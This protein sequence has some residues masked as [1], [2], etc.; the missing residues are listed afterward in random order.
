MILERGVKK[1]T[2]LI[3]ETGFR[4]MMP[5]IW[6]VKVEWFLYYISYWIQMKKN[7]HSKS[8]FIWLKHLIT[9]GILKL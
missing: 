7:Y 4:A 2:T 9:L 8:F 1:N 6:V 5:K 3:Y